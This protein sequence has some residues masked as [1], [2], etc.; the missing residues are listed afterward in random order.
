VVASDSQRAAHQIERAYVV[1][2]RR[3]GGGGWCVVGSC[4]TLEGGKALLV[5]LAS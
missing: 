3:S 1:R 5:L 2:R 4:E